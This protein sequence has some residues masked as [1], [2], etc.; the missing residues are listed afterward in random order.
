MNKEKHLLQVRDGVGLCQLLVEDRLL[1]FQALLGTLDNL[2]AVESRAHGRNND[3]HQQQGDNQQR[4]HHLDVKLL[5]RE[6]A[7]ISS[8]QQQR[9]RQRRDVNLLRTRRGAS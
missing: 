6:A 3:G 2:F 9:R 7:A 4:R 5:T 8:R 1:L